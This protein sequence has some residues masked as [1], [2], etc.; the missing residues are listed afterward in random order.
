MFWVSEYLGKLR[1]FQVYIVAHVP[2]GVFELV[3]GMSWF[4]ADYNKKYLN[5]LQRYTDVIEAQLYGH[6]HT[7]SFRILF[8]KQGK[9]YLKENLNINTSPYIYNSFHN[10]VNCTF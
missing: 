4:Y 7:D 3:E 10:F 5:I 8:D 9:L 1:Y 6:E 2:P